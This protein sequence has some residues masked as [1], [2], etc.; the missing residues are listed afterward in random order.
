VTSRAFGLLL[1]PLA[2]ALGC[3]G[4][5]EHASAE[6]RPALVTRLDGRT[7]TH[8]QVAAAVGRLMEAGRVPGLA[9]AILNGGE[10]V[11][12]RAFGHRD[13]E[14]R[15]PLTDTT[16]MYAASF[17]KVMFAYMVM[18]LVEEGTLDL[19]RPVESYLRQPLP[20]Y[21]DYADLARDA[22]YRRITP[23]MLLSHT[24]GFRN[25]RFLSPA[26]A[27]DTLGTLDIHFEPGTRYS[28]SGEGIQ[29][30]QLVVEEVTGR[31]TAD[32][33]RERVFDR[34]G[35]TRTSMLWEERFAGDVAVGYDERGTALGHR[36]RR[37][38]RAAGSVDSDLADVARFARGVLRGE[39]LRPETRAQMLSPQI[40]INSTHQFPTPPTDTTD[41]DAAIALSY[42][43]GWGL[44]QSP[45]GR[46]YFKEGHDDGTENYMIAFDGPKTAIVIMTNSS[47]GESIFTELLAT[48]IGDTFT[49]SEWERYVPYD[50]PAA[51]AR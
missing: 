49:P 27:L 7:L 35:M 16:V 33:M 28:Y 43:L 39:G 42:G 23:R 29:L 40:R 22:R 37:S 50:A 21:P 8:D 32:L 20:R 31:S 6:R 14:R 46:A 26:G 17:T 5:R 44:L 3:G 9:L 10:I 11:Y 25:W 30:L 24:S 41:R 36:R 19:D 12:Q 1:A 38:V 15:L 47:N 51:A 18:Q 2:L 45:Y 4:A 34:F 48:L 13:V